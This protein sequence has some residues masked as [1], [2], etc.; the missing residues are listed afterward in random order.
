MARFEATIRDLTTRYL[1]STVRLEGTLE[2]GGEAV[3]TAF[4]YEASANV[5]KT[6]VFLCTNRH[7]IEGCSKLRI[8]VHASSGKTN[9]ALLTIDR[10]QWVEMDD[11]E[12]YWHGHPDPEIDLCAIPLE[13]LLKLV[14]PI[15][16]LFYTTFSHTRKPERRLKAMMQVVM[17]GYPN[18]LWDDVNGLPLLR[19]GT[20]AS[21]PDIPFKGRDEIVV[22]IACF[23]GSSGSPIVLYDLQYS[24]NCEFL[25][26]L[27]AGPILNFRG[28]IDTRRAMDSNA[29]KAPEMMH[30]GYAI[31]AGQ[32]QVL[33]DEIKNRTSMA[34]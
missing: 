13:K 9:G 22:D 14:G 16:D 20:T 32:V 24:P 5:P 15:P 19:R 10:Q 29:G 8:C 25:G 17:I 1:F 27:Y 26:V 34:G 3:G 23:P 4:F 12:T 18:G 7:V 30:L 21:H 28:E 6:E 31:G 33:V 2:S 11:P